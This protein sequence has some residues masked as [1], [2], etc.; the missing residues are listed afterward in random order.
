MIVTVVLV[1]AAGLFAATFV[2]DRLRRRRTLDLAETSRTDTLANP[3]GLEG[4][5]G[6]E[7]VLRQP[8][9]QA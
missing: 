4:P 6:A 3:A 1:L 9:P 7:G 2:V 8:P 5:I